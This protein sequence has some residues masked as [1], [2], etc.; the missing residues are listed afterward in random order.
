MTR[1][2]Y[3]GNTYFSLFQAEAATGSL[4][5][6]HLEV[7]SADGFLTAAKLTFPDLILIDYDNPF[8]W[9]ELLEYVRPE[10]VIVLGTN[11]SESAPIDVFRHGASDYIPMT[12]IAS[13]IGNLA[14]SRYQFPTRPLYNELRFQKIVE[15]S[16]DGIFIIDQNGMI[17]YSSPS[18]TTILGYD[19]GEITG[20]N[21]I[22]FLHPDDHIGVQEKIAEALLLP[23]EIIEGHTG[24]MCHKNGQ[25]RWIEAIGKNMLHDPLINGI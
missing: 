15:S 12:E 8:S 9:R 23:G 11:T 13:F 17:S 6:E 24:R 20:R 25:W 7:T 21:L 3:L 18:V 19:P 14:G 4:N 16:A 5:I 2:L 10:S 1:I 22:E